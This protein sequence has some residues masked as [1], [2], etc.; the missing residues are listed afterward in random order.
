[1]RQRDREMTY[2]KT[3]RDETETE[4]TYS[5]TQRECERSYLFLS[6][7]VSSQR[8]LTYSEQ[9]TEKETYRARA[10]AVP[11]LSVWPCGPP[12]RVGKHK[13]AQTAICPSQSPSRSLE[14]PRPVGRASALDFCPGAKVS[15]SQT[16]QREV[17][18]DHQEVI[19][20]LRDPR[21]SEHILAHKHQAHKHQAHNHAAHGWRIHCGV[22]VTELSNNKQHTLL[23]KV[24]KPNALSGNTASGRTGSRK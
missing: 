20:R 24:G 11:P 8:E 18:N 16:G 1:M 10:R 14:T 2:S 3:Q 19:Q 13:G 12:W 6:L 5:K 22:Q 23:L 17:F 21:M 9:E 15:G 4:M 7:S